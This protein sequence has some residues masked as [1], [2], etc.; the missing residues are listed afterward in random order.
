MIATRDIGAAAADALLQ[1]A[2]RGK[3][4]QELLGQR[5]LTYTEVATII[6]KAIG[7]PNLGYMQVPL[8]MLEGALVQ[9]GFP[10]SSAGLMIE[11][12][13]A[14][15]SGLCHQQEPRSEAN[16]TPTT[17]ETF[18]AEEFAPAYQTKGATA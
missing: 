6:G 1:L 5:D 16:T 18:A 4:A 9:M 3:Q 7:K 11:M 8:A 10:K 13:K 15:N 14:E 12:F 17:L 2:F